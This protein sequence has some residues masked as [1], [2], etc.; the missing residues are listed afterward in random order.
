MTEHLKITVVTAGLSEDASTTRLARAIARAASGVV[1]RG[2]EEPEVRV[3]ALREIAH[4]S[5]TP[6]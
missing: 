6:C 5:R 4:G 1:A 2:G 3:V